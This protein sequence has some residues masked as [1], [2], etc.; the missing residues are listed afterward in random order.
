M[1]KEKLFAEENISLLEL[2]DELGIS[3][4][5][6]SRFLNEHMNMSFYSFINY[7]RIQEAV[8]IIKD[9]K[10]KTVLINSI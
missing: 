1:E 10:D 6:L 7:H 4:H 2:A 9:N 3:S 5:Q 8:R